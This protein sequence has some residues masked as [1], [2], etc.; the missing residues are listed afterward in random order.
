MPRYDYQCHSCQNVFELRQSF[1]AEPVSTCPKCQGE[2]RRLIRSVPVVFKG[3]GFYV[4]DYGKGSNSNGSISESSKN[5]PDKK[6]D[7]DK[8]TKSETKGESDNKSGTPSK[9]EPA[10]TNSEG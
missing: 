1:S 7:L 9:K 3:S 2:A 6:T 4:N 5:K 8:T 10:S